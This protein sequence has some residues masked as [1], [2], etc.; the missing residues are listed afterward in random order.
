MCEY[1]HQVGYIKTTD[2]IMSVQVDLLPDEF[3]KN[4]KKLFLVLKA[5]W[6]LKLWIRMELR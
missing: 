4:Y 1:P 2:I 5:F 6:I 3:T